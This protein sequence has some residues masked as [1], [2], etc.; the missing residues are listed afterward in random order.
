MNDRRVSLTRILALNWYGF[1][2]ILEVSN[3]ILISGKFGTGKS[4][5][6]DLMQYVL[7]GEH[8]RANRAAAG[9]ARGR[10]LVSYCLCD[11]NT[12]R[13]GEPHF[14]RSSGVT[15]IGLEFSWPL[16]QG[17][18]EVRRETWG[19]RIEYSSATAEPKHTGFVATVFNQP[20]ADGLD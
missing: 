5:L 15:V 16:E 6:L 11:T 7:L 12:L 18:D 9:N 17:K 13:E 19:V 1:R 3:D 14:T 10:S 4:A 8:W 2:Q 20:P